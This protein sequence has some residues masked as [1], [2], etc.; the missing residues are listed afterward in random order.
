MTMGFLFTI[1]KRQISEARWQ[2]RLERDTSRIMDLT[3][4]ANRISKYICRP[5]RFIGFVLIIIGTFYLFPW[6][7]P[8]VREAL[9][10]YLSVLV[11]LGLSVLNILSLIRGTT[12]KSFMDNIERKFADKLRKRFLKFAGL[13]ERF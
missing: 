1:S 10:Q 13:D 9:W 3:S 7:L 12:L 2:E 8:R 5:L 11:L 4:K 6:G